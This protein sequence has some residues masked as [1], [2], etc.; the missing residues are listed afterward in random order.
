[1]T[2]D[3]TIGVVPAVW[4]GER[5]AGEYLLGAADAIG[6]Q[7][8]GAHD[9][10]LL[11]ADY[12]RPAT[13]FALPVTESPAASL[14]LVCRQAADAAAGEFPDESYTLVVSPSGIRAEA[15]Y[16]S[17]LA[18]AIQ[19]LRQLLPPASL[20][21]AHRPGPWPVPAVRIA[22]RPRFAWRGLH[23][24]VARHFF[25]VADVCRFIDLLALHR[26]N[27]LHLHL[28]DDQGWR[29]ESVRYPRLAE[30]ASRR[31]MTLVGHDR[32]RPRRYDDRPHGG[33][34]TQG[35]VRELVA[36]A[37]RRHVALL[38]EI[39][40]P[41]H[42]QAAIAAYPE[43][44][45][46]PMT[47]APRCH[48]GISQ[49]I[50]NVEPAT[51]EFACNVLGEICDLFPSR[52]IH[53][54]G[55]EAAKHEWSE[56]P[57]V[58]ARMAELGLTDEHHLQS[59]FIGK[60]GAFL[61][62]RGRCLIGWDEILEGG[63]P[64]GAAVMS[65]RGEQGGVAAAL[66]GHN[67]VMTPS[68]HTYFDHFQSEPTGE[69]PLAI[70][71]L[72]TTAHVYAYEPIPA[73]LPAERHHLVLGTQG[74]LWAEYIGTRDHLDYMTYPRACA[75]AEVAWLPRE[76]KCYRDF[77]ARLA[78]HRERLRALGVNAHPLP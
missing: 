21:A 56:S 67:V 54:G 26:G 74:Q 63:L 34:Y 65:W 33:F 25:G 32:E 23:L 61:Q 17:G 75:L 45:N 3:A 50:L 57:R 39:D 48:W 1:M 59:W 69:E 7:G 36:Y 40:M 28:T 62:Q 60:L 10:A 35:E 77:L 51:L 70:G 78:V 2:D 16:A 15:P 55:D 37:A 29:V 6:A 5:Q 13:G 9:V 52:L 44:G 27:R 20:G 66:A 19:T 41:G 47:P 24:D 49:H 31:S 14:Q 43:L 8:P 30:V 68:S 73:A 64:A 71:G 22:D 46:L 4:A 12:L 72:T 58:Q 18:R 38:P 42:M 53:V 76:R 11:L